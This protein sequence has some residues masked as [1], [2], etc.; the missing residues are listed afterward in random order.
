MSFS[1]RHGK[2]EIGSH[3]LEE[4]TLWCALYQGRLRTL[5]LVWPPCTD[6]RGEISGASL[7]HKMRRPPVCCSSDLVPQAPRT[8]GAA[9]V[10]IGLNK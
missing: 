3:S 4:N 9:R 8:V 5:G 10:L 2:T 7:E 1:E 6:V